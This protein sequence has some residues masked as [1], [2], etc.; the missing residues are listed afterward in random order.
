MHNNNFPDSRL[1]QCKNCGV[2][3]GCEGSTFHPDFKVCVDKYSCIKR[4]SE[5]CNLMIKSNPVIS[6]FVCN[7]IGIYR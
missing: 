3:E 4:I 2:D 5:Q 6:H 1:K 7:R